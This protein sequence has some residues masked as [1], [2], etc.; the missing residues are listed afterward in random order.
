MKSGRIFAVLMLLM[1]GLQ[2]VNAQKVA[3]LL[4]DNQVV[5]Y[6]VSQVEA[7]LFEET[8]DTHEYVDLG[9]P[10]GTLWATCNV[11]ANSP[12]EYGDYISWGETSPKPNNGYTWDT[13]KY[14]KGSRETMTKYNPK[15]DYGYL[16]FT[17][18]LTEL[19][20]I[21]DA[22]TVNWGAE[23]QMPS[24]TQWNELFN[25]NNTSVEVI[26]LNNGKYGKQVTSKING[27]SIFLPA[28]GRCEENYCSTGG[29]FYWSRNLYT[30]EPCRGWYM[31]GTSE[32]MY[33]NYAVRFLGYVVR[34]VR[35][36]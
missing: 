5:K 26:V 31:Y 2:T 16:G 20:A 6:D 19:Q 21:D 28:A 35:R 3:V 1:A 24:I 12:E 33:A 9:L 23:W 34:P 25:S 11:G 36:K 32:K 22:A 7:V 8:S 17:D 18:D 29:Y 10:S 30:P 27:N 13:Y 14:C 4:K 15:S